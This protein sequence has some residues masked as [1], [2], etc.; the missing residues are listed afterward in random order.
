[1]PQDNVVD[2]PKNTESENFPLSLD[3]AYDHV[4]AVRREYCD[5][6]TTDAVEAVFAVLSSYGINVK[7]DEDT[8]KNIV[9]MEEAVK[10]LIYSTKN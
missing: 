7:T 8:I 6:I 10:S 1:M 4:D 5:E 2:F 9:F 3:D